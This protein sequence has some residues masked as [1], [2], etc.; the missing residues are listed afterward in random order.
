MKGFRYDEVRKLYV[1]QLAYIWVGDSTEAI[2][3]AVEKKVDSFV[4]GDL[5]HAAEAISALWTMVNQDG[6]IKAPTSTSSPVSPFLACLLP[7]A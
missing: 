4:E 3:T 6:E 7:Q 5:E 1:D 2:R